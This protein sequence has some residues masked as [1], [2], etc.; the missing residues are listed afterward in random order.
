M[1]AFLLKPTSIFSKIRQFF[2]ERNKK[3]IRQQ[4]FK[5]FNQSLRSFLLSDDYVS[6]W[7]ECVIFFW[8]SEVEHVWDG[9]LQLNKLK[10]GDVSYFQGFNSNNKTK[11]SKQWF[12]IMKDA[13]CFCLSAVLSEAAYISQ[14]RVSLTTVF[15]TK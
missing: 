15:A 2:Y 12:Y 5:V 10:K 6:G 13:T 8:M 14:L 3:D 1:L 11:Q 7:S 9:E 4:S